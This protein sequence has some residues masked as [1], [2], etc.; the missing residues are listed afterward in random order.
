[1]SK[2]TDLAI[3]KIAKSDEDRNP[4]SDTT[5]PS[6]LLENA[7]A[8]ILA[9]LGSN[10]ELIEGPVGLANG[11]VSGA[12]GI[13]SL[14]GLVQDSE[15]LPKAED[16]K[17]YSALSLVP[18]VSGYRSTVRDRL[19]DRML[20]KG[21]V[22]K[23]AILSEGAGLALML[24]LGAGAGAGIAHLTDNS[25]QA[26]QGAALGAGL[27][28]LPAL[29]ALL[30]K[31]RSAK[32]HAEYLANENLVASNILNPFAGAYNSGARSKMRLAALFG[33]K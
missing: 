2:L 31:R 14:I 3:R 1:M 4:Y 33:G 32:Q 23:K 30:K 18:G 7:P 19:V 12:N 21:K 28:T 5:S 26:G 22:D 15:D 13:G 10:P 17:N 11:V 20:S 9:G 24:A 29:I 27:A 16:L 8:A 6:T 25:A